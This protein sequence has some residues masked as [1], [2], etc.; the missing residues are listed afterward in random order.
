MT[1]LPNTNVQRLQVPISMYKFAYF[2]ACLKSRLWVTYSTEN[3]CFKSYRAYDFSDCWLLSL[4][5]RHAPKHVQNIKLNNI[6]FELRACSF[7]SFL[8][9]LP[10]IQLLTRAFSLNQRLILRMNVNLFQMKIAPCTRGRGGLGVA[11]I[12]MYKWEE[13]NTL[14]LDRRIQRLDL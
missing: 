3:R 6:S 9:C 12:E 5:R 2:L 1:A 11:F 10:A 4:R 7:P 13:K 14:M 8:W